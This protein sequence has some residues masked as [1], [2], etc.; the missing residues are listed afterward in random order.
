MEMTKFFVDQAV[1]I[2]CYRN[3]LIADISGAVLE[4]HIEEIG[5]CYKAMSRSCPGGMVNLTLIQASVPIPSQRVLATCARG[6]GDTR[7]QV[8]GS[9][10]V[11]EG[12]GVWAA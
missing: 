12:T 11:L 5:R 3:V 9:V 7:G 10:F 8:K 4:Q 6:M 2:G 1:Y